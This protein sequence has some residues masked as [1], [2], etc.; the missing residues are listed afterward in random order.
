[1]IMIKIHGFNKL[2]LLDYPGIMA[3]TIF[4]GHC[5]FRCPF[6][7]NS[8]LVLSPDKEP[9]IPVEEVLGVLRK[10]KGILDGVCIT[11]GEPTMSVR[12][13]EFISRIKEMGYLVK[14]DT[15]GSHPAMLKNLVEHRLVDYVAMDI[16]NCKEK[17][18]MTAGTANLDL[19]PIEESVEFLKSGIVD[20]EFRTTVVKELHKWE[21]M[22][23]IG[24]WI[25]GSRRYFLQ[26]YEESDQVIRP[27][28]S[29]Y[30][31]EQLENYRLLL[32]NNIQEVQ[33]RG[34]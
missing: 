2:T 33:L 8:G 14:L 1:M 22:E 13:P 30:S 32:L 18:A 24:V 29:S 10:R 3:A 4:L 16:K 34:V 26:S 23:K 12:L 20:Y 7:H 19:T 27:V 15:N 9:V 28:F 25:A 21:D 5:N 11:G 31:K 6:C 17:Y